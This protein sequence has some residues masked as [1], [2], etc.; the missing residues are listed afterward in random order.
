MEGGN[1]S[2]CLEGLEPL[3]EYECYA[4]S[5][6][7]NT[8][9][10]EFR[11]EDEMQ[12]P[13]SGF[14]VYSHD[15]SDKYFS[16]YDPKA[17]LWNSKWWD[18]GNKGSTMVGS[19]Y[20]ICT[21][22]TEDKTEGKASVKMVSRNVI[23]KFAAGNLFAGE[24]GGTVGLS[25]GIVNFGRPFTLRPRKLIVSLKYDCGKVDCISGYPDGDPVKEGDPD[26]CQVWIAVGDWD[27]KKYGGTPDSPVQVNTTKKETLFD[28][29][30]EGVIG[31]GSYISNKSVT[32]WTDIEIPLEY[33]STSRVPTH[34]IVSCAASMLGDY[35]TGSSE[36]VL[37]VDNMRLVY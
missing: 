34:I 36:S 28:S 11:T 9:V 5:G 26:R 25:G 7:F 29:K 32:N 1:F 12:L 24:F 2:T 10:R 6:N 14:E 23:I 22:D 3:T 19:S 16:L 30:S 37:R 4:F 27:Y 31:Y 8:D 13:N 20:S 18:S 17:L 33:V 35:F 15:E 21:I